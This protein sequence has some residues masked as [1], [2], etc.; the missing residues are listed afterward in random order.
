MFHSLKTQTAVTSLHW[1][2]FFQAQ[3]PFPFTT[4]HPFYTHPYPSFSLTS[5]PHAPSSS[6]V[7]Q[8]W[9]QNNLMS[10]F[11]KKFNIVNFG[12]QNTPILGTIR[13]L[14]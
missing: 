6:R 5:L 11:S 7:Y 4:T 12:L 10:K 9:F 1:N 2:V 8:I 3:L 14:F 13:S